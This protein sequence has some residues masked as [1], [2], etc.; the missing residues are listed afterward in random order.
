MSWQP[1]AGNSRGLQS[2]REHVSTELAASQQR[3]GTM[4]TPIPSNTPSPELKAAAGRLQSC[5][6]AQMSLQQE[7]VATQASG[8]HLFAL[9]SG[10]IP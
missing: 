8:R 9:H 7:L 5:Y 4:P 10:R 1:I 3:A 2:W 6:D